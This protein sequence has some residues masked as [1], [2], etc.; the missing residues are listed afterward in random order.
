MRLKKNLSQLVESN[1]TPLS[2]DKEGLLRGGFGAL[3]IDAIR[4][5]ELEVNIDCKNPKCTNGECNNP[6]CSN[7]CTINYCPP[8]A[9]AAKSNEFFQVF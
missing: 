1:F 4:A 2:T 9:K 6:N 8:T 5:A 3:K 7:E